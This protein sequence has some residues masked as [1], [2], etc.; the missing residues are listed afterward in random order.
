MSEFSERYLKVKNELP[1]GVT[2]VAAS[3]MQ[4]IDKVEELNGIAP[5]VIFGENKVQELLDKYVPKY[6]WHI[7]GQ[8]QSNKVKYIIDKVE[9][10]QSLDRESLALEI[11]KQAAKHNI[12]MPCLVEINIAGEEAKGGLKPEDAEKFIAWT[13]EL[14]H[15]DVRGLMTVAPNT[16][17]NTVRQCFL[18]MK[19]LFVDLQSKFD[20]IEILSMGMSGDYKIAIEC[21][22]NM[23]RLGRTLFGERS[24]NV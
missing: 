23:V 4:G 24:Y 5:E 11:E 14:K 19:A 13:K 18:K 15:V 17:E 10:I 12:V 7:I 16:D 22:S 20:G 3:K 9:L 2:L 21:G 6:R 1:D 8:L